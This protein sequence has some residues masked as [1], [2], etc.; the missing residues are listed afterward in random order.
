MNPFRSLLITATSLALTATTAYAEPKVITSIKPVHSLVAAV[1][2]GVGEPELIIE[3]ASSPH[4]YS[5]KPSQAASL[6]E[7]EIIFW[8][9]P[10]L[11][12]FL[13]KPINSIAGNAKSV[14]LIES[15]GLI[16]L[17]FREG[18]AFEAHNHDDHA[19]EQHEEHEHDKHA[20]E[21]HEEH[22]HDEHAHEKHEEHEEHAHEK[23][24]EHEHNDHAHEKHEEHEHDEH[25][26]EKHEEHEH[27]DHGHGE[28]DAHLWLDPVN[29][30]AFL[31]EIEEVLVATD[32]GNAA[33]YE[34]NAKQ[35]SEKLDQLIHDATHMLEPVR[36]QEFVVFHDAYQY[37]EKRFGLNATGSITVNP[38]VRPGAERIREIQKQVK[39]LKAGCVFSEPQ[40]DPKLVSVILE[41]TNAKTGALDPL[42]ASIQPGADMY[43]QLI[44]KMA[45][46]MKA[47][48]SP[49][50]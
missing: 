3:G 4:T 45:A 6:Q 17:P 9:G 31:H 10:Q 20:H 8:V 37:F 15:H 33:R 18:G 26:H 12:A 39:S 42:G 19:H 23:H 1:M 40:F 32:P 2:D 16:K 5:L 28:F 49:S 46:S 36:T 44:E 47:C 11:E 48:L 38:D 21:K 13:E 24:E 27:D 43:L 14:A 50:S 30:K 29:A 25:A 41:G 35:M 7:A 34:A 22:G